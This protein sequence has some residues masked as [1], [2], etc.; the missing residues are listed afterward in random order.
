MRVIII[1]N[2]I[3]PYRIHC[4]KKLLRIANCSVIFTCKENEPNRKWID[5]K[6]ITMKLKSLKE[7]Q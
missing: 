3:P 5:K 4:L 6:I 2:M 1:T 7:F